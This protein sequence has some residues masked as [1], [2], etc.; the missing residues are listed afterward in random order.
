MSR[1]G[2]GPRLDHRPPRLS[3]NLEILESRDVPASLDPTPTF[4]PTIVAGTSGN[5]VITVDRSG[6]FGLSVRVADA[7][8]NLLSE[9]VFTCPIGGL[10]VQGLDGHDEI[11]N[12]TGWGLTLDGG[13]G[14]RGASVAVT[15]SRERVERDA[16]GVRRRAAER[17]RAVRSA[18]LF[19]ES[20][21]PKT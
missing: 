18:Q 21:V 10:I 20:S 13:V 9:R 14:G 15:E 19:A 7:S 4:L 6:M 8:G 5:D 1:F 17:Q 3:L 2:S 11:R 16:P 12:T